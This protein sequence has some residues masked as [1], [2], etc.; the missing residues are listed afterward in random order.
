[1]ARLEQVL[2]N[3]E[4]IPLGSG[5]EGRI[6]SAI[7]RN[8]NGSCV[9]VQV[10]VEQKSFSFTFPNGCGG[11]GGGSGGSLP[12]EVD[13]LNRIYKSAI[14]HLER[15]SAQIRRAVIEFLKSL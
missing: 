7:N 14:E 3:G 13:R 2:V 1:M 8:G 4:S 6:A 15:T 5:L 11:G 12:Q 10:S 9:V